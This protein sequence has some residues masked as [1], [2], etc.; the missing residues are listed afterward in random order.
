M[1]YEKECL[2]RFSTLTP[3]TFAYFC[4]VICDL[5][6]LYEQTSSRTELKRQF[7]ALSASTRPGDVEGIVVGVGSVIVVIVVVVVVLLVL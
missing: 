1:T 2:C 3:F 6:A 5:D 4:V 7:R